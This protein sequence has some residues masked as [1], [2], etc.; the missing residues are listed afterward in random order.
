MWKHDKLDDVQIALLNQNIIS[1]GGEIDSN[2]ALY[3]RE[4]LLR[5]M[6]KGSP[7][8]KVMITSN[9]GSVQ[10]G[11]DIYDGLRYYAGEKTGV[12]LG[13]ARS[14]AAVILQACQKRQ[15]MRHSLVLIHHISTTEMDLDAL[16]D[17]IETKKIKKNLEKDQNRIYKI[18]SDRTGHTVAEISAEC[19]KN[20]SMTSEEALKFGLIDEVI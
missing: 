3:V 1:I 11:L 16:R 12:V 9:G 19:V 14:M 4:A 17:S 15:C 18:L 2:N 20:Q 7:P 10:Y 8:I 5:L 13:A 6:G